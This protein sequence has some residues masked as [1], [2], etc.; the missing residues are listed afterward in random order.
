MT[1]ADS[2]DFCRAT[3]RRY[4]FAMGDF[5]EFELNCIGRIDAIFVHELSRERRIFVKIA[6]A[7]RTGQCEPVMTL[8]GAINC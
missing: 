5:N 1:D 8:P 6:E 4:D 7:Q 2:S 3:E